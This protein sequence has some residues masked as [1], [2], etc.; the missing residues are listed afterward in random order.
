[1]PPVGEQMALPGRRTNP[2]LVAA[3]FLLNPGRK[4]E[5]AVNRAVMNAVREHNL[6]GVIA[7]RKD[8]IYQSGRRSLAWQK[9]PLKPKQEFVI[10]GYRPEGGNLELILVGHYEKGTLLFAGKVRQALNPRKRKD[11]LTILKPLATPQCPF[12]NLPSSGTGH[13]GEGVTAEDMGNYVWVKPQLV[14]QV[15]FTEWTTGGVLRH[16]E[17][18]GLRDEKTPDEVIREDLPGVL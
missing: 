6:E 17:F 12:A 10:G 11:L 15:K 4:Y 8:S 9:L 18:G 5:E 16:A 2:D 1:M 13:W 7:K 14:A 3:R